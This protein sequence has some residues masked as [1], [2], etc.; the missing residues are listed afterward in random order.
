MLLG[1]AG[2]AVDFMVMARAERASVAG[3]ARWLQRAC[4]RAL[5]ALRV[6]VDSS[7]IEPPHGVMLAPNHVSYLDIVVL[8]SLAPTVFVA[9]AEVQGW[10]LF[11][12]FARRGGTLFLRR[13]VRADVVRVGQ[14]L[15]PVMAEGVNLVVFLEG[16]STDGTAVRTFRSSM[17]APAVR[18]AWPVCPVALRYG[19]PAGQ[20]ARVKVA[21]WG[22]M[23]LAP[24]VLSFAALEWVRAEVRWGAVSAAEG[25]RKQVARTLEEAVTVM[26]AGEGGAAN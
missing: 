3:R 6:E 7:R 12:W 16:T 9:K 20:D 18:E 19:V 22:T 21:W 8:A 4:Q 23:P 11:G 15:S 14:Q 5:R 17:L 13:E 26:L 10:P 24:H 25:D 2:S 1:A